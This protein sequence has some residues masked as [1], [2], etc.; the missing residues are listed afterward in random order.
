MWPDETT[1]AADNAQAVIEEAKEEIAE[2]VEQ[3]SDHAETAQEAASYIKEVVEEVQHIPSLA[4]IHDMARVG[5]R[6]GAHEALGDWEQRQNERL[7]AIERRLDEF[8]TGDVVKARDQ[9][10]AA[11]PGG[12]VAVTDEGQDAVTGAAEE[13]LDVAEPPPVRAAPKTRGKYYRI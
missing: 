3:V 4:E 2:Q 6:T 7:A 11:D 10:L 9:E 8:L 13:V 5:A 1:E 12:A